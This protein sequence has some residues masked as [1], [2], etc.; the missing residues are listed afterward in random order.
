P[1][2]SSSSAGDGS[3]QSSTTPVGPV[4]TITISSPEVLTTST[5]YTTQT[6]TVTSC[7]A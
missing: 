5:I 6:S 2:S 7:P 4:T 1:T 3:M